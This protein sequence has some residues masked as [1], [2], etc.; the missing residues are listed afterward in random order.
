MYTIHDDIKAEDGN[1]IDFDKTEDFR[2]FI[3]RHGHERPK[4]V[5]DFI[6]SIGI[7]VVFCDRY[8]TGAYNW[9]VVNGNFMNKLEP[10][11]SAISD[12]Y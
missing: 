11:L 7:N 5:T 1:Q 12:K 8:K 6:K 10:L 3:K 2:N 9:Y 4:K